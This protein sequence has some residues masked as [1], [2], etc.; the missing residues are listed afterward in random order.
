MDKKTDLVFEYFEKKYGF[1][2]QKLGIDKYQIQHIFQNNH[3]YFDRKDSIKI[4]ILHIE[5]MIDTQIKDNKKKIIS[6]SFLEKDKPIDKPKPQIIEKNV[7]NKK[8]VIYVDSKDRDF[9]K[10]KFPSYFVF[11]LKK[12]VTKEINIKQI[13]L[14][15]T[16]KEKDSSDNLDSIPYLI[17]DFSLDEHEGTNKYLK[18]T[19]AILG[20]FE[21]K[22]DYRYYSLD[23]TIYLKKPISKLEIKIRKPNGDIYNFGSKNNDYINTVCFLN[24]E[25]F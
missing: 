24:L 9:L 17:L 13:I 14:R 15:D 19:N 25:V 16:N 10:Y 20:N 7:E 5:K 4:L 23:S 18:Y 1:D 8:R 2:I 6:N 11:Q 12:P 3:R 22:G 21:L